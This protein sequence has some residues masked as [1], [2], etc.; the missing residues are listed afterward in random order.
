[1]KNEIMECLAYFKGRYSINYNEVPLYE[2]PVFQKAMELLVNFGYVKVH[3]A[4]NGL[5]S[6]AILTDAGIQKYNEL[7]LNMPA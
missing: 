6:L 3:R 1:M 4:K 5:I 2:M 7:L